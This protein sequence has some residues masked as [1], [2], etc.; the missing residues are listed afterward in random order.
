[1]EEQDRSRIDQLAE[2]RTSFWLVESH[3]FFADPRTIAREHASTAYRLRES[4]EFQGV[5][6]SHYDVSPTTQTDQQQ[7]PEFTMAG[8]RR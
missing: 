6:V 4:H 7:R 2:G 1:M 8:E 5:T 3:T